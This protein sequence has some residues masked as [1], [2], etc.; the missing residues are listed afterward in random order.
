MELKYNGIEMKISKDE[1]DLGVTVLDKILKLEVPQVK[2][3]EVIKEVKVPVK[4]VE[5]KEIV[6][7][8]PV[9]KEVI[10]EV[11][12][13]VE[14]IV[15]VPVQV[16]KSSGL[17]N[18]KDNKYVCPPYIG[19]EFGRFTLVNCT[20]HPVTL[21]TKEGDIVSLPSS[22]INTRIIFNF[23]EVE[24][25]GCLFAKERKLSMTECP[26]PQPGHL[27]IVSRIVY[28]ACPDRLDFIVPNTVQAQRDGGSV[29]SVSN[30]I[31]RDGYE[32]TCCYCKAN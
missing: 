27:F 24:E 20:K 21:L 7:E 16:S 2:E 17:E 29:V 26:E 25:K 3:V 12:K 30:F 28:D 18:S 6:K 5:I 1:A 8:V 9:E 22:G 23:E 19:Y 15:E 32:T 4:E 10:K 11:V 31:V 13:E 14:K